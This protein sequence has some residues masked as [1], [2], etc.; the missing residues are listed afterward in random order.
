ME[1]IAL[2]QG[3]T[4]LLAEGDCFRATAEEQD[5]CVLCARLYNAVFLHP[6]GKRGA[7]TASHL[8]LSQLISKYIG[9]TQKNIGQIFDE[10]ERSE[11]ILLFDEADAIFTRRSDVSDA[12]DC[13]SN[14]ETAYLLQ[15]IQQYGGVCILATNLLQNFDDAFRRR[16]SYMVH[17]PLPDEGLRQELWER[18]SSAGVRRLARIWIVLLALGLELLSADQ[19]PRASRSTSG[20]CGRHGGTDAAPDGQHQE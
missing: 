10:A 7:W 13:Y 18:A 11:C 16:I 4:L 2:R 1:R 12:Q 8:D 19:Q 5:G 3:L 14:A 6:S 17:F 20:G 9:E 15:R